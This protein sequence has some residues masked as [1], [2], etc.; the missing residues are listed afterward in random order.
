MLPGLMQQTPLLISSILSYAASAHDRREIVSR[1][2]EE[3]IW[4]Y[5]YAGLAARAGR[6][7]L[8][9]IAPFRPS[10]SRMLRL[11]AIRDL[12]D[13]LQESGAILFAIWLG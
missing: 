9:R 5:D 13:F 1:G 11:K 6:A 10:F 7:A 3:P 12:V 4:R 8:G 2:I